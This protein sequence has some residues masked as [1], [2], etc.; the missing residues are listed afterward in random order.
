MAEIVNLNKARKEKA[1][2]ARAGEADA[3]RRLFGRTRAQKQ[4]D[5]DAGARARKTLDDRRLDSDGRKPD[6]D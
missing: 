1:R 5:R 3:N 6:E 4:A 2:R